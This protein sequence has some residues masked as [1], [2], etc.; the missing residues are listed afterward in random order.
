MKWIRWSLVPMLLLA[1]ATVAFAD[2]KPA[3]KTEAKP[4]NAGKHEGW[5]KSPEDMAKQQTAKWASTLKLTDD[6]KPKFE[7]ILKDSY[8]K[9]AD[10]KKA[11]GGDKTKMKTSM[12]QIMAEQDESMSK[13]LTPDQMKTYKEEMAKK[14]SEAKKHWNNANKNAKSEGSKEEEKDEKK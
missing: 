4:A 5:N 2:D 8:Q 14:T 3:A 11:A 7:S 9:T 6:Q 10:A 13:L 12:Q 1:L